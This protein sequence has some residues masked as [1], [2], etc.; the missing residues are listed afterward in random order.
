M[1]ITEN[2]KK[3]EIIIIIFFK[4]FEFINVSFLSYLTGFLPSHYLIPHDRS[5]QYL[6]NSF[7]ALMLNIP[8]HGVTPL[9]WRNPSPVDNDSCLVCGD[10]NAKRHYGAMSCNGCKGFFRRRWVGGTR[11]VTVS[12]SRQRKNFRIIQLLLFCNYWI[13]NIIYQDS[14]SYVRLIFSTYSARKI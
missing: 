3:T 4:K 7:Q 11:G 14:S 8:L 1:W 6:I 10:P 5:F 9:K 2:Q 13:Y 12:G